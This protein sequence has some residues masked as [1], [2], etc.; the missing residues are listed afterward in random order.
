M[1]HSWL[2]HVL[3][4]YKIDPQ[5]I[6]SLQQLT[7][8]WTTTLQ[9]KVKNHRIISEPICTQQGIYQWNSLS[10]LWFC[11]ALNSLSFLLN[12][13]S[14]GLV[15]TLVNKKCN[16]WTTFYTL[17]ILNYM[18]LQTVTCKIFYVSLKYFE[19][20]LK[21]YLVWKVHNVIYCQGEIRNKELH[22]R[23]GWKN[24]SHERGW[25]VDTW[26]TCNLNK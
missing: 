8:K 11:L 20:K 7:K 24:G 19:E 14:Y 4:K 10:R 15:Y 3:Q 23:G 6:N 18:Q 25:H 17:T 26:A 9:V 12:R 13:T 5:I 2:I 16:D 21:W 1:S 22:N